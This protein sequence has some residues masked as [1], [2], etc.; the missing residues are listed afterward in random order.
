MSSNPEVLLDI[1]ELSPFYDV[2]LMAE[3]IHK[4]SE[5]T[6]LI[7]NKK[8]QRNICMLWFL[9]AK[10]NV[11]EMCLLFNN[12]NDV[13]VTQMTKC[14]ISVK[15]NVKR[16]SPNHVFQAYTNGDEVRNKFLSFWGLRKQCDMLDYPDKGKLTSYFIG[17]F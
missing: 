8:N 4:G 16:F 1:R 11:L 2:E 7:K 5:H 17:R 13:D 6:F 10:R 12:K 9:P 15:N 3:T 14:L